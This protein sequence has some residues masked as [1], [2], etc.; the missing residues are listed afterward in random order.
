MNNYQS[1]KGIK[2]IRLL[3]QCLPEFKGRNYLLLKL[4]NGLNREWPSRIGYRS[5]QGLAYELNLNII[6][7]RELFLLGRLEADL[8]W[9]MENLLEAG[10]LVL[11]AGTDVGIHTVFMAKKVGPKGSIHAFDPLASAIADTRRHLNLNGLE[12][13]VLNQVALGER[14]GHAT[15]YSFANLPRAHS[16]LMNLEENCSIGQECAVTTIDRYVADNA[17]PT[18]KLLKLDIEGSEMAALKGAGETVAHLHPLAV[19]EAN[20]TTSRAFGYQPAAIVAWFKRLSY[21]CFVFRRKKWLKVVRNED[22]KHSDNLLFVWQSDH[23]SRSQ[24]HGL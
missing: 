4:A 22:I 23:R 9:V 7:Q 16:S 15:V 10:D 17:I 21:D 14:E 5:R 6:G 12:N 19:V 2:L 13:V 24:L 18:L 8:T 1:L 20:Y 11:E 3:V